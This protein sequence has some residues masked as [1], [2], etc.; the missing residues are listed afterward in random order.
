MEKLGELAVMLS[1]LGTIAVV[2]LE[3]RRNSHWYRLV[4]AS[5]IGV[6]G[7][8][9]ALV[10]QVDVVPDDLEIPAAFV[11]LAALLVTIASF[12]FRRRPRG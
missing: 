6:G 11:A 8:F 1:L 4:A 10:Q 9:A 12:H 3:N 7:A 5:L 2:V